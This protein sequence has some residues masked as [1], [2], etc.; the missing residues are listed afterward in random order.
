MRL[1]HIDKL[2]KAHPLTGKIEKS[3]PDP[4]RLGLTSGIG[5]VA[6]RNETE[7][8]I[9]KIWEEVLQ[10]KNIGVKDD[11]FEL[12]GHSLKA[13]KAVSKINNEFK[14]G[15]KIRNL[16]NTPTIEELFQIIDFAINQK[17]NKSKM[18]NLKEIEL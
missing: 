18:K 1:F 10:R 12:G 14:S 8:K 3:F 16:F 15:I 7:E 13:T 4:Q 5:Y 2:L 17:S 11:F 6:P 9:V